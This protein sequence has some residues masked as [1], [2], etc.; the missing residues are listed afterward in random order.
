MTE[1]LI[2]LCIVSFFAGFIDAIVGGGGLLQTPAMLIILPQYPVATIFGTAKIPSLSGTALAA[3]KYSRSVE[4][5]WKLLTYI[6]LAAFVGA[7]IGAYCITLMDSSL[8]KP[9]ILMLLICIAIYTYSKKNLGMHQAKDFTFFKEVIIGL[10]FGFAIGFYDGL[11]GPGT[12]TFLVLAFITLLGNDFLHSS[13]SAKYVNVATNIA[14][15]IYFASSGNILYQYAFPMAAFNLCGSF[16][17]TRLALLKGNKFIRIFFLI[18]VS[19]TI[20]RFAYDIFIK[21]RI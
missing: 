12:G 4:L 8:I 2:L 16:M 11:I 15:M 9:F 5:N 20:L 13:A 3:Y 18:V 7:M 6:I 17:G 21:P 1:E 10:T 19:G 14:A